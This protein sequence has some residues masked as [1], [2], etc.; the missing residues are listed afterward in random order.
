MTLKEILKTGIRID[1]VDHVVD[2]YV[3]VYYSLNIGD[4]NPQGIMKLSERKC[5]YVTGK[6]YRKILKQL[7][8]GVS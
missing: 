1:V 3:W 4:D 7:N 2:D 5:R 6:Y 8:G